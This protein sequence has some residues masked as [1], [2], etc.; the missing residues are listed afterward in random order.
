MTSARLAVGGARQLEGL[1][2]QCGFFRLPAEISA[3][4]TADPMR[5]QV[6]VRDGGREHRVTF[7]Y[8]GTP[9][10]EPL[11]QLVQ[12]VQANA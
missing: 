6:T 12:A 9:A 1:V 8:D 10:T 2:H 7:A 5:Y 11:F 4:G 3:E